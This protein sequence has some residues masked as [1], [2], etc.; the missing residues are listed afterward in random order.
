MF[1]NLNK[2]DALSNKELKKIILRDLNPFN[3]E[4]GYLIDTLLDRGLNTCDKCGMIEDT[5]ELV[6][7]NVPEEYDA[8][9]KRCIFLIDHI[10]VIT[11]CDK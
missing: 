8:L 6:W 1:D 10:Q 7:Y 11:V 4:L 5:E 2:F 3:Y 9:C